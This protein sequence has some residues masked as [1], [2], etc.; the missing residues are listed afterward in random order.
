MSSPSISTDTA[1]NDHP[2]PKNYVPLYL[3][4]LLGGGGASYLLIDCSRSEAYREFRHW[5]DGKYCLENDCP[6][7]LQNFVTTARFFTALSTIMNTHYF[8][9]FW[10]MSIRGSGSGSGSEP[11]RIL[12][13]IVVPLG[14]FQL[15]FLS[16]FYFCRCKKLAHSLV[17]YLIMR[18]KLIMSK[19]QHRVGHFKRKLSFMLVFCWSQY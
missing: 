8:W 5:H 7:K 11:L 4:R 9:V 10:D 6:G 13:N 19:S 3:P 12:Y 2:L 18:R 14:Y 1:Q 16:A 15:I 17:E